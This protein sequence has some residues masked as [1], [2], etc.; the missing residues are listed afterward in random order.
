MDKETLT[1]ILEKHGKWLRSEPGG[2]RADLSGS[3]LN[4]SDL[5]GS[6]LRDADLRDADLSGSDLRRADLRGSILSGSD[7]RGSDLRGSDLDFSCLPL[8]CGSFGMKVDDWIMAQLVN[9]ILSVDHPLA[10]KLRKMKTVT[11]L[12]YLHPESEKGWK[13]GGKE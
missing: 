3:D 12:C 4:G 5:R 6:I 2:E 10:R 11:S 9:H 7:L 13:D 1:E 8:W